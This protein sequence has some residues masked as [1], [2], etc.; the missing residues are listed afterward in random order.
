MAKDPP[1]GLRP[2]PEPSIRNI[3][4]FLTFAHVDPMIFRA[5]RNPLQESDAFKLQ[6]KYE[7]QYVTDR[8]EKAWNSQKG[9]KSISLALARSFMLPWLLAFFP[10]LV[11]DTAYFIP[12]LLLPLWTDYIAELA[13][14]SWTTKLVLQCMAIA[15]GLWLVYITQAIT[16][17][18]YFWTVAR[19]GM[20]GRVALG[21]AVFRKTLRLPDAIRTQSSSGRMLN[22]MFTD[23]QSIE[24]LMTFLH[25]AWSAP[26]Q[27]TVAV[28]MLVYK[29]GPA[30]LIG[31]AILFC[32]LPVNSV[33]ANILTKQRRALSTFMDARVQATNETLTGMRVI[34][35]F[36]FEMKQETSI[37]KRRLKEIKMLLQIAFVKAINWFSVWSSPLAVTIATFAMFAILGNELTTGTTFSALYLLQ[38]I[39]FP[40]A[41]LPTLITMLSS[42]KVSFERLEHFLNLPEISTDITVDP[43]SD[44]AIRISG[45]PDFAYELPDDSVAVGSL[46]QDISTA[47]MSPTKRL[48][49]WRKLRAARK[50][51]MVPKATKVILHDVDL[52]IPRG[53]L[54]MVVGAVGAGKTSLLS[55]MLGEMRLI[56]SPDAEEPATVTVTG[57]MAVATQSAWIAN[58]TLRDNIIFG[59]P[60]DEAL[61]R[62]VLWASCLVDDLKQFEAGDLVEIGEKGITLSGGQ[63]QRVAIA[64]ALYSLQ[65]RDIFVFDDPLAAVDAHVAKS[66]F[67]RAFDTMLKGKTIVLVTHQVQYLTRA[68][69]LV[70]LEDGTVARTGW[71]ADLKA[72]GELRKY[73]ADCCKPGDE[74]EPESL[75]MS[76]DTTPE[77]DGDLDAAD[78]D[79]IQL[80]VSGE[81]GKTITKETRAKGAVSL[82]LYGRY[83]VLMGGPLGLV[84]ILAMFVVAQ[85]ATALTS[86]VLTWWSDGGL[87]RNTALALY[88]SLGVFA[89]FANLFRN[90][91]ISFLA[92]RAGWQIHRKALKRMLKAPMSYFETT[93]TGRILNRFSKDLEGVD[94]TLPA[95]LLSMMQLLMRLIFNLLSIVV[96]NPVF[97]PLLLPVM[98]FYLFIRHIYQATARELKRMISVSRSPI[99]AQ[100]EEAVSGLPTLRAFGV[101]Q[102]YIKEN[103]ASTDANMRFYYYSVMI[104]RWLGVRLETL[105]GLIVFLICVSSIVIAPSGLI[106]TAFLSLA[107]TISLNSTSMLAMLIRQTSMMEAEMNAIERMTELY[108]LPQEKPFRSSVSKELKA[109]QW[110]QTGSIVFRDLKVRYRPELPVVL[111]IADLII[112]DGQ[113]VGVVGRTGSGKSTLFN[114]LF[115]IIEADEGSSVTVDNRCIQDLG[116]HD[117]RHALAIIPQDPVLFNATLRY[118]LDPYDEFTDDEI[119][120]KLE[121]V[122]M[123]HV[124]T[125]L[126]D[127]IREGGANLSQGQ[128]QLLCIAR[129]VLRNS[130]VICLDEATASVDME[131]DTVIQTMIRE[132]F[133]D[134]TVLTVAHRLN[135][136]IDS[137][138]ILV[139]DQG[140]VAE[141]G[142]PADL[143]QAGGIFESLVVE[144]GHE[145]DL[146]QQALAAGGLE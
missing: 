133:K 86:F 22:L 10:K 105:G 76:G 126:A 139:L 70:A 31:L 119:W 137:D 34:K 81:K 11:H 117:V 5:W 58:K 91:S 146:R 23:S 46:L 106:S 85:G 44:D 8:F 109:S 56:E 40:V 53:K 123:R 144:S 107:L 55:A 67:A 103:A 19:V 138:R 89:L 82:V 79:S 121:L 65:D 68:D 60:Y 13:E 130:R 71:V 33:I 88:I 14:Q 32:L 20:Q 120:E 98:A 74:L 64:R 142:T 75:Q 84:A 1:N 54:T 17:G 21:H 134:K 4:S 41:F 96:V 49:H 125:T 112:A 80:S 92:V 15:T 24:R 39:Q 116:L 111:S 66:L 16:L 18:L 101:G 135:T 72:Q 35:L 29:L 136:V 12:A 114:V 93:P 30:G 100:F 94:T 52:A 59:R 45:K 127:P 129:A 87:T 43:E 141:F 102:R 2:N 99:F 48:L 47:G 6:D 26:Y 113:K 37:N 140:A 118:N 90:F 83:L 57:P 63:K 50:E 73:A 124:F 3:F 38:M 104:S 115:R 36:G 143:V 131:T 122:S 128:R 77:P 27:L 69:F 28:G 95:T 51:A 110:P 42:T 7:A 25:I 145:D 132:Q 78:L 108:K 62:K 9:R 61:Y 97:L